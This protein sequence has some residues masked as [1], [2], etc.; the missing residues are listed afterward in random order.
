[1]PCGYFICLIVV[2]CPPSQRP[3]WPCGAPQLHRLGTPKLLRPSPTPKPYQR[4]RSSL[5]EGARVP[6]EWIRIRVCVRVSVCARARGCVAGAG[7]VP[8][9]RA[10]RGEWQLDLPSG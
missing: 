4:P 9:G 6:T 1:M 2:L 10:P 3:L 7:S 8:G 5:T